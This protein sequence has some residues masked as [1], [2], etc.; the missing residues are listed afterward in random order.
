LEPNLQTIQLAN[1]PFALLLHPEAVLAEIERSGR[2]GLLNS[3]ICRPLDKPLIPC[4]AE[5]SAVVAQDEP[6]SEQVMQS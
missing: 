3:R 2:L 5:E 6:E 4:A 1:N